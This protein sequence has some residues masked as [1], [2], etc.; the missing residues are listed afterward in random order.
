MH[1]LKIKWGQVDPSIWE[2]RP[3]TEETTW[4]RVEVLLQQLCLTRVC[5]KGV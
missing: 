5:L 4:N 3:E 1:E 2:K